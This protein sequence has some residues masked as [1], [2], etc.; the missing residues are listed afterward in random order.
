M[1]TNIFRRVDHV[2]IVPLDA[3]RS[4]DF[5]VS[6]LGFTVAQRVPVNMPPLREVS[7]LKLGDTVVEIL[8]VET[9]DARSSS[10]WQI[11]YRALALEVGDM[12]AAVQHLQQHGVTISLEPRDLGDSFRGEILDPDGLTIEIRQWKERPW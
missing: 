5:Y 8:D 11:G 2:E 4:I 7:Y 9:P 12:D 3:A 1:S 6:V 10:A